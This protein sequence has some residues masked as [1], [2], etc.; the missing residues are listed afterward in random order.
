MELSSGSI[1]QA[2]GYFDA[3][4]RDG[5]QNASA[6]GWLGLW[7]AIQRHLTAAHENFGKAIALNPDDPVALWGEGFIAFLDKSYD[8]AAEKFKKSVKAS[9]G[10]DL[11]ELFLAET[12][13]AQGKNA[14]AL[15]RIDQLAPALRESAPVLDM[16]GRAL[17]LLKRWNEAL[18]T[19]KAYQTKYPKSVVPYFYIAQI[20]FIQGNK[21][22]AHEAVEV[23]LRL[24]PD[25]LRLQ[26]ARADLLW[27][28]G[29]R[30]EALLLSTQTAKN[31]KS[32]D[33]S[34]MQGTMHLKQGHYS[35]A[36][37]VF[38][39]LLAAN[40][41]DPRL[42]ALLYDA[43]MG[44][45][46]ED[47]AVLTLRTGWL[48]LPQALALGFQLAAIQE[49]NKS[50]PEAVSTYREILKIRPDHM[51]ALNQLA[52][53]LAS[54]KTDLKDALQAADRACELDLGNIAALDTRAWVLFQ[55]ENFSE[56]HKE[57]ERLVKAAPDQPYVQYHWGLVLWKMGDAAGAKAALQKAL[58]LEPKFSEADKIN[59]VLK[60][61]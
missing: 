39:D 36:S 45:G 8:A 31:K 22:A 11:S 38:K 20:Q 44:L 59:E 26:M 46:K 32:L 28:S 17:I 1:D 51:R 18:E 5:Q 40:P 49:K 4:V 58:Q 19:W 41:D 16:R 55:K 35:K 9:P 29:K 12:F 30:D 61:I 13:L 53:L 6:Y 21:D 10:F 3:A 56:A 57:L 7:H 47:E 25:D 42:Y 60:Q 34:V 52:W 15:K 48:R 37:S 27:Q 24:A 54:Q 50:W 43:Q 2:G 33:A 23:G 14:E